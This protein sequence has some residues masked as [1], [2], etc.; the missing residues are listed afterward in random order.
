M[1]RNNCTFWQIGGDGNACF[2]FFGVIDFSDDFEVTV[3]SFLF[4]LAITRHGLQIIDIKCPV[5]VGPMIYLRGRNH[6][7]SGLYDHVLSFHFL[8]Y[9]PSR[10]CFLFPS[11]L[12]FVFSSHL[13]SAGYLLTLAGSWTVV[14]IFPSLWWILDGQGSEWSEVKWSWNI[15]SL[16]NKPLIL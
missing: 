10:N 14:L 7:N 5:R 3:S 16:L 4:A 1:L 15:T 12:Q 8:G 6:D 9:F 11:T 13:H 2:C